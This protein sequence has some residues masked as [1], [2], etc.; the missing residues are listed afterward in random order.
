MSV[1]LGEL[2][3]FAEV[4]EADVEQGLRPGVIRAEK[5]LQNGLRFGAHTVGG[6]VVASRQLMAMA[7]DR[8]RRNGAS[9]VGAAQVLIDAMRKV[10]DNYTNA[11]EL[12]AANLDAI[13]KILLGALATSKDLVSDLSPHRGEFE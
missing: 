12:S 13:E 8:A 2:R 3:M 5:E 6:E 1:D 9:Q 10:L 11:D 7:L 4:L